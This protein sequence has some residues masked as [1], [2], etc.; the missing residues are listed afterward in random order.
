ME[1]ARDRMQPLD[2]A[3][4]NHHHLAGLHTGLVVARD[5]VR[6]DDHRLP[7]AERL[8]RHRPGRPALAAKDRRQIAAAIAVQQ[9]VDDGEAGVLDHA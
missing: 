4:R 9:I 3:L 2:A 8:L 6:L 7:G 1:A 5:D